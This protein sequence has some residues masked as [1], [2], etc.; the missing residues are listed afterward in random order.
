MKYALD[1]LLTIITPYVE[2]CFGNFEIT[3]DSGQAKIMQVIMSKIFIEIAVFVEA[4][5]MSIK[6]HY[7][8]NGIASATNV[9]L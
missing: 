9:I 3:V 2:I 8:Y 5:T 1:I 6:F 7:L 4:G